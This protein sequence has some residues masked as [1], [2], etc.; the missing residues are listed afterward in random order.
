MA[1]NVHIVITGGTLD[2]FYDGVKDTVSTGKDSILPKYFANLKL[3][4]VE[5]EFTTVCMKDSRELNDQDRQNLL[6]TIEESKASKIIITHGTY[7]MPDSARFLKANL[8]R[9]DQTI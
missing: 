7:T 3:Q 2:S 1:D 8:K 6:K 5:V 9:N 4:E